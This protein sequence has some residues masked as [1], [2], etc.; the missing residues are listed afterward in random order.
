MKQNRKSEM[1]DSRFEAPNGFTLIE[2]LVVIAIIGILAALLLPALSKAK[3]AAQT[4]ACLNNL[5]QLQIAW[6][7]YVD[8]NNDSLPPNISRKVGFD[9]VNVAGSWVLGNVQADVA[10]TNIQRGVIYK[11][12]SSSSVYLCPADQSAVRRLSGSQRSRSYSIQCWHNCDVVSGTSLDDV[13]ETPFNLRKS[14]RIVNPGPSGALVLV[15][16][17][18]LSIDDGIFAIGNPYAF[19]DPPPFW[20]SYPAYRH[21]NGA[22]LSFADGHAEHHRWRYHRRITTYVFG[23]NPVDGADDLA[24]LQWLQDKL[25]HT[26]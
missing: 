21:N 11:Y 24:D 26:P 4:T 18:E 2:L 6:R 19:P 13:N 1:G 25:P 10:P 7:M 8:D 3:A 22:N 20:G 17:H 14:A 5:K 12:A 16:E 9:Q 15:D 23:T